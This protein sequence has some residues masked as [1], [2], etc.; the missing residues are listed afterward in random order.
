[1]NELEFVDDAT[2]GNG[3]SK[4]ATDEAINSALNVIPSAVTAGDDM[5]LVGF[6]SFSMGQRAP[7]IGC[8][9][10]T[11]ADIRIAAARTVKFTAGKAFKDA[12]NAP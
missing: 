12:V 11:G 7:G 3:D 4:T 10:S 1:M 5:Q 8:N 6:G 2:A 9:P